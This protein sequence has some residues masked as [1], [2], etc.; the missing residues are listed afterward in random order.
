MVG[1][2]LNWE[3]NGW[4]GRKDWMMK[5]QLTLKTFEKA[6]WKSNLLAPIY[7]AVVR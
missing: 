3:G 4:V 2:H 5:R 7:T 1:K 6:I